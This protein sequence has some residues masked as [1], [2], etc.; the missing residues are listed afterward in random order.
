MTDIRP[1]A[2]SLTTAVLSH[3]N[4]SPTSPSI[5]H[6]NHLIG[7]Y[8]ETVP[9]ET[10]FRIVKRHETEETAVC[11]RWPDEFWDDALTRGGGGTCFE[12]NLAFFS[13]LLSLGYE[14]YLTINN[15]GETIGCHTAIVIQLDSA[16][17]LV[18]AGL[19]IYQ[20]LQVDATKDTTCTTPFLDYAVRPNGRSRYEIERAPHP[21][22]NAFTLIDILVDTDTYR[23][24]TMADYGET[25][26]F[27]DQVI[28]NRVVNGS[29]YRFNS[30][31]STTQL[32]HFWQGEK[33]VTDLEDAGGTAVA[34]HFGMDE[35]TVRKALEIV[36]KKS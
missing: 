9:W 6:L 3:L 18:D 17:W 29:P 25:G 22:L 24:A 4:V 21:N 7:R 30:V 1:L 35:K 2:S 20:P 8:T 28:I 19:P 36:N 31:E 14:G 16:K 27:L 11:P 13:L 26:L 33:F 34:R 5:Q 15:M 12:S 23:A 32:E 10:A